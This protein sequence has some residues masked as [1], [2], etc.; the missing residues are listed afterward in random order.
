MMIK[1]LLAIAAV[2]LLPACVSQSGSNT[3]DRVVDETFFRNSMALRTGRRIEGKTGIFVEDG[4]FVVCSAISGVQ[5]SEDL[6]A[7]AALNLTANGTV[8]MRGFEM[9][10]QKDAIVT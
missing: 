9:R 3:A 1:P 5:Q 6:R 8:I 2:C 7:F 4:V 10:Q